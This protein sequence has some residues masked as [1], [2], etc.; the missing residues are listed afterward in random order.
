MLPMIPITC[1]AK[2]SDSQLG[3][4]RDLF[5]APY[6]LYGVQYIGLRS[7]PCT[8][9]AEAAEA[10]A[11]N[12]TWIMPR[13]MCMVLN[14]LTKYPLRPLPQGRGRGR[15]RGCEQGRPISNSYIASLF[16]NG[17][18]ATSGLEVYFVF[19]YRIP[20][21]WVLGPKHVSIRPRLR[22]IMNIHTLQIMHARVTLL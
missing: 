17:L 19:L 8:A 16:Q 13:T 6:V 21:P 22:P 15:G 10:V 14:I 1:A 20:A 11:Q 12:L 4:V 9:A 18:W 2:N 3:L 5:R 7:I